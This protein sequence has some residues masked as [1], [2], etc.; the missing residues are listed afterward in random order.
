MNEYDYIIIGGGLAGTIL[1]DF[2]SKSASVLVFDHEAGTYGSKVAAGIFNPVTGR[3][4]VKS[5]KVDTLA[6]FALD[7]YKQKEKQLNQKLIDVIDI[8]RLFNNE[9]QRNEW[10]QRVDFDQLQEII[11]HEV[12]PDIENSTWH[13]QHGG[14]T[15][16]TSWRLN[17]AK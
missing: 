16:T 1:A 17:T 4:M 10:L 11:A 5:W 12:E 15:T 13:N 3:R 8:K 14:V 2:L 9:Q 6:P 7:Y